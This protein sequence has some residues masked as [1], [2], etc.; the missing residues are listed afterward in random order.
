MT[1]TAVIASATAT[2]R[3]TK[4]IIRQSAYSVRRPP[5]RT[6]I[7]APAPPTAPQAASAFAR[8]CPWKVLVMIERAAGDSIAAPRP[9]PARAANRAA[10]EPAIAD[11]RDEAVKTARPVTKL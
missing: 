9:W 1:L 11:A 4:K 7:A 3:L 8:A 10:A 6:P 2:G 5:T